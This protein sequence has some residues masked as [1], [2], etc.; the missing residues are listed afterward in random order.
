VGP[1]KALTNP[2]RKTKINGIQNRFS[3]VILHDQAKS[4]EKSETNNRKKPKCILAAALSFPLVYNVSG[5]A[6]DTAGIT[7]IKPIRPN[8]S[9]SLVM[10]YTC[11]SITINCI[12]QAKTMAKRN[13]KK[14]LN[15]L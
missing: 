7:S 4:I 6:I 8:E 12:D 3:G 14:V 11:H 1:K 9:G 10:L 2:P 13:N 15:S 5:K